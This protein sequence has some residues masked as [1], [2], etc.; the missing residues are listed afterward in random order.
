MPRWIATMLGTIAAVTGIAVVIAASIE[1]K[2]YYVFVG[3]LFLL[4]GALTLLAERSRRRQ[5]R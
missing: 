5:R 4:S 3:V 2:P 1:G